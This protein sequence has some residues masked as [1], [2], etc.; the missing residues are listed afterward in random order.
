[1]LRSRGE[2]TGLFAGN[3]ASAFRGG[4]LE[5]D[6]SRPYVPGDDVR[7]IDWSATARHGETYVKRRREE[8]DQTLLF[9]LDTSA[10]MGFGSHG[11]SKASTAAHAIALLTSAASRAGDRMGL[12]AFD[13][14]VHTRIEP[15]RGADHGARII[16]AAVGAARRPGGGTDLRAGLRALRLQTKRR[17][18][19]FLLSDLRGTTSAEDLAWLARRHDVVAITLDRFASPILKSGASPC[20][21]R[22]RAAPAVATWPR[23]PPVGRSSRPRWFAS[24]RSPCGFEPISTRW[25]RCS[26]SSPRAADARGVGP[27]EGARA[28]CARVAGAVPRVQH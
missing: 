4:G 19:V 17:S 24:V 23:A 14:G 26:G 5:F 22:A 15:G 27:H 16:E 2:A 11:A 25:T 7:S 12:V 10:S 13:T 28:G 21:T 3:Y 1:V 18:V 20:S 6:E 8:R 9:A